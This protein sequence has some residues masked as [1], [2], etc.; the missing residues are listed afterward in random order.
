VLH[1]V[2]VIESAA[3][4]RARSILRAIGISIAVYRAVQRRSRESVPDIS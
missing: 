1:A 4:P 2:A 3:M